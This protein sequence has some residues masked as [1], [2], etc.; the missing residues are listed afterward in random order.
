VKIAFYDPIPVGNEYCTIMFLHPLI[1]CARDRGH[2]VGECNPDTVRDS[3]VVLLT[4]HL[5]EERIYRLKE[6]GNKIIGINVTDSSYISGAIRYAKSLPLVDLIFMV[7]GVQA[8]N[9]DFDLVLTDDF[10]LQQV[11]KPFLDP[12]NWA[13]FD[14]LVK[15]EKLKSLPYVPWTRINPPPWTPWA[16]RSQK[17][18]LRGGGHSRRFM[19]ALFLMLKDRLD[20][21]SGF[22][23]RPYFADDMNPQFRFCE[24]C[25][26]TQRAEGVANYHPENLQFCNSPAH[27]S[28]DNNR[29]FDVKDLGHW[30]NRCPNSF[31]WFAEEFAKRYGPLDMEIVKKM[32][33]ARWLHPDEH[34]AMLGRILFTS[35]LKWI[36]SIYQPQRYWE[37]AAA[38]CINVLPERA[39]MQIYFPETKPYDHYLVYGEKMRQLDMEFRI[40]E[41]PYRE[42]AAA[43]RNL[44]DRWIQ[45]TTYRTNTNLLE[46]M[47]GLMDRA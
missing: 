16:Q 27:G 8:A 31:F 13:V 34:M 42:M 36:H 26:R 4:D 30:N 24:A 35:D 46:H 45:P 25:R 23:L 39:I 47:L 18:I 1:E 40:D 11:P 9:E 41:G 10:E 3:H 7:S 20:P 22:V 33:N 14:R 5:T 32:L 44:F 43:N 38:G 2:Q 21:N 15:A 28:F 17:T 19:L 6:N 12:Q 29:E 37:A